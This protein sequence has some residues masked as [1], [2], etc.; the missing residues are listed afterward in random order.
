MDRTKFLEL[1]RLF[2]FGQYITVKYKDGIYFPLA[3]ELN[4]NKEGRTIHTAILQ[5]AKAKNLVYCRLEDVK[6]F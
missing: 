5:D 3:Y 2:A 6:E 4:F 1:C